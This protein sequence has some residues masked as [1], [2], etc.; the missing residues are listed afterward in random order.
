MAQRNDSSDAALWFVAGL[1]VGTTL[2]LLFAP[3]SGRDTRSYLS[4][5]ARD[6]RES[7]E[8]RGRDLLEKSRELFDR[9]REIADEAADMFERGRRL[10]Q[11]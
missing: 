6:S 10:V 9:G 4:D 11:D 5:R 2:S 3:Q 7:L 1:A 8:A